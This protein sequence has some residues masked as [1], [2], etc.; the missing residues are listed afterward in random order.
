VKH[1]TVITPLALGNAELISDT[2]ASLGEAAARVPGMQVDWRIQLDGPV[3]TDAHARTVQRLVRESLP[4][5]H[6]GE[7]LV[8]YNGFQAGGAVTRTTA[9]HSPATPAGDWILSL[10]GDDLVQ[11]GALEALRQIAE[12]H[13]T[14]HWIVGGALLAET[15]HEPQNPTITRD[16]QGRLR[17]P[18]TPAEQWT[19]ELPAVLGVPKSSTVIRN[20]P[21][22]MP[23]GL[24]KPGDLLDWAMKHDRFP[25]F[26]AF[27]AYRTESILDI[28]GWLGVP[29]GSDAVMLALVSEHHPGYAIAEPTFL[30]AQHPHQ[31]T[32][33]AWFSRSRTIQWQALAGIHKRRRSS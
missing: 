6:N 30:Y 12:T 11:P 33:S 18:T 15:S 1:A 13:P 26:A 17:A 9:F 2:A 31:N 4:E 21:P 8:A 29:T 19:G 28:G 27:A 3:A 24:Q 20:Y 23:M 22:L 10:D 25:M 14:T 7:V 16:W 5:N 32:R